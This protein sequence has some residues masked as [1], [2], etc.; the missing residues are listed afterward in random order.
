MPARRKNCSIFWGDKIPW[1]EGYFG[2]LGGDEIKI[3]AQ[4]RDQHKGFRCSVPFHSFGNIS[5][6]LKAGGNLILLYF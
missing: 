4:H 6:Q 3:R 2:Y 1:T 5:K